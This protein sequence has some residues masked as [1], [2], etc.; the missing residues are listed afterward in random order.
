MK[1][2]TERYLFTKLSTE[3]KHALVEEAVQWG[4]TIWHTTT[5]DMRGYWL[6]TKSWETILYVLRAA[7]GT[8]VGTTTMKLYRVHYGGRDVVIVKLGL[9]VTPAHRGNKFAVRCLMLEFLRWKVRHPLTP[10]YLFSTLI[11]PVTYKLCCDLLGDRVYPH[12]KQLAN[13]AMQQ[14]VEHLTELF[15]VPK[16][17]SPSPFVYR[18]RFSA[19]E[20]PQ[21]IE[22]W[23]SSQR[24]EVRFYVEQCPHY[25]ESRD[26]LICLAHLGLLHVIRH[27]LGTLARNRMDKLRGRKAKFV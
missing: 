24:P 17:D 15:D 10:L 6:E 25:H 7:D 9:G 3:A 13:P 19:I 27:M 21:A 8:M 23:R 14:M 11:H 26:C 16:A 4:L 1:T 20:T 18:E 2:K 22:Y 5:D 12:F